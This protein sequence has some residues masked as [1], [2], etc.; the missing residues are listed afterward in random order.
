MRQ[1]YLVTMK[2]EVRRVTPEQL[3]RLL[4]EPNPPL[5]LDVRSRSSYEEDQA[6][7]PGSVRVLPDHINEW[8][9]PD[10]QELLI[11]AYCTW[12][13]EATSVRAAQQLHGRGIDAVALTGGFNA[14]RGQYAVEPTAGSA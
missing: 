10:L 3:K 13:D 9:P 2:G 11:V 14:W 8:K 4:A 1:A 5:V 12:L 6:R 7:I